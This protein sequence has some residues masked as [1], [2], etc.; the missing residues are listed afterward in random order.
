MFVG[1][2]P[3]DDWEDSGWAFYIITF[4]YLLWIF[5]FFYFVYTL[6]LT[7]QA[8]KYMSLIGTTTDQ[9]ML[10][11]MFMSCHVHVMFMSCHVLLSHRIPLLLMKPM[12]DNQRT[13]RYDITP[14]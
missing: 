3:I 5:A 2:V 11:V 7:N 8:N 10:H 4:H 6:T 9:G 13:I 14:T 1:G 12:D